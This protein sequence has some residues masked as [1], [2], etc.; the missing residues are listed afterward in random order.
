MEAPNASTKHKEDLFNTWSEES[1]YLLGYLEA[2]GYIKYDGLTVR[3]FFQCSGKD[4]QFLAKLKKVTEFTGTL[5]TSDNWAAGKK[6]QKV[7]FTVS[8]RAWKKS[9]LI[10]Q[11]RTGRIAQVPP[12][13]IHH[14]IRGY[15]DGDGSIFWSKQAQHMRSNFVFNSKELTE[16]FATLLRPI[17]SAK[18]TIHK[19]TSSDYCWYFQLGNT[20]TERLARYIYRDVNICL[21]RKHELA[22][23]FL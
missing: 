22:S 7:R 10:K 13:Y 5:G 23:N 15:F 11:L 6:Y 12:E 1:T 4:K 17:V 21:E 20:A 2:D 9:P 18:L 8:S 3:I 19:K 14:Y 16:E